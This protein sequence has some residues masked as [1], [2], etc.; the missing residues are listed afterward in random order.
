MCVQVNYKTLAY[1]SQ[2]RHVPCCLLLERINDVS[3]HEEVM[4]QWM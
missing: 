4:L 1:I 3:C 2:V